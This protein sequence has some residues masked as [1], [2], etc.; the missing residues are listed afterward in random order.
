MNDIKEFKDKRKEAEVQS[1]CNF[2]IDGEDL[3]GIALSNMTVAM[4]LEC[5]VLV[6]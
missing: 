1:T 3:I 4:T 2:S 5:E 6:L